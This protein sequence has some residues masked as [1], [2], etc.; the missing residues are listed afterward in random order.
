M[1][2]PATAPRPH[3]RRTGATWS[4]I[5]AADIGTGARTVLTQ[6]AADA[7]GVAPERGDAAR[8]ATAR[9]GPRPVAGG[10]AGT[11]SWGSAVVHGAC[12]ALRE[13]AP[14]TRRPTTPPRTSRP[15]AELRPPRLRRAVRRGARRRRHRRGAR[16]AHARRVRR[17]PDP[18]P[19]AGALAA[20]RRHD[21]GDRDGAARGER[22]RRASSATTSTTTS[23]STTCRS[24][25]DIRDIEAHWLDEDDPHLNPMGSKGIGEIGIVGTAAAVAN[26]VHHA[27]GVRLRDAAAAPGPGPVSPGARRRLARR[28]AAPGTARAWWRTRW[29]G[30]CGPCRRAS[31][32]PPDSSARGRT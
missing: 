26:A 4:A 5:G 21:H 2:R 25:A 31:R 11:A 29:P 18:Q 19:A 14:A 3:G 10:S 15:Q 17:R 30:A 22:A 8:S 12:R 27:T 13:Q 32:R 9:S 6:I 28:S 16:P 23:R 7:L 24:N 1:R 20:H